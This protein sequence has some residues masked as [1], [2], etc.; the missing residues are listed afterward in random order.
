MDRR[1]GVLVPSE[2]IEALASEIVKLLMD[3]SEQIRLGPAARKRIEDEFSADRMT[4]DYLSVY[5]EAASK[6]KT[7]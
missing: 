1:T 4:A 2:N 5:Q 7:K 6:G 3:R